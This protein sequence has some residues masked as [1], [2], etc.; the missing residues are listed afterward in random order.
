MEKHGSYK[1][2]NLEENTGYNKD[3]TVSLLR[4]LRSLQ[5]L[6]FDVSLHKWEERRKY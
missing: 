5:I 6:T 3:K 1:K 2:I 4:T